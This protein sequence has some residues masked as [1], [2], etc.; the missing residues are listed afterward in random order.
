MPSGARTTEHGRP[1]RWPIIHGPTCSKNCAR[2]SLVTPSPSPP[3]GH[4]SLSGFEITTPITSADLPVAGFALLVTAAAALPDFPAEGF[5]ILPI[6]GVS[7]S[8]SSAG[9]SCRKPLN[10][11]CLILPPS[12]KPANSI[13]A[14]SSG[15]SQCTSR[16]LRGASLP[17]NG[18]VSEAAA[19]NAGMMRLTVSCPKPVPTMPTKARCSPR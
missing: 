8:T 18:L 17:P 19:F 16:V 4:S 12:V 3:S 7:A 11:A 10:A 9:L 5:A 2:S 14:T 1:L 15:F 13:S 6:E